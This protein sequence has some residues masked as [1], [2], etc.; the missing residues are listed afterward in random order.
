VAHAHAYGLYDINRLEALILKQV[1]GEF[2]LLED[3]D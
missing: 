2:F 3:A 1:R